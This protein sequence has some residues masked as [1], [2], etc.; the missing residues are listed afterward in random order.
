MLGRPRVA[1][2]VTGRAPRQVAQRGGGPAGEAADQAGEGGVHAGRARQRAAHVSGPGHGGVAPVTGQVPEDVAHVGGAHVEPGV[3]EG[4]GGELAGGPHQRAG[5]GG[6]A[7]AEGEELVAGAGE[8]RRVRRPMPTRRQRRP[9]LMPHPSHPPPSARRRGRAGGRRATPRVA[10]DQRPERGVAPL[11]RAARGG[12]LAA[13]AVAGR[14]AAR[15]GVELGQ[16]LAVAAGRAPLMGSCLR[17]HRRVRLVVHLTGSFHQ[18]GSL[19]GCRPGAVARPGPLV[20]QLRRG[21]TA[22]PSLRTP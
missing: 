16:G 14:C 18:G 4:Q 20:F 5:A 19:L 10:R 15:G 8:R 6:G 9:G 2:A 22:L 13:L 12:S 21:T 11:A 17:R 7:Q 1:R 3:A